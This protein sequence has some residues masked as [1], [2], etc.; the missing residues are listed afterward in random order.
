MTDVNQVRINELARELEVKAKAIIDLLPGYGVTEKKTHSS[1]IPEDVAVKVRAKI[2]G[3][4]EEESA[5]Q[6]A[7]KAESQAKETAAKARTRPAPTV[8][9]AAAP[10]A[11][12][13]APT[14]PPAA[15]APPAAT[16][17]A[18]KPAPPASATPAAPSVSATPATSAPQGVRPAAPQPGAS[19]R[20]SAPPA[21]PLRPQAP[22]AQSSAPAAQRPATPSPSGLRPQPPATRP[23]ASSATPSRAGAHAS[24]PAMPPRPP[25]PTGNRGPLPSTTHGA[26]RPLGQGAQRPAGGPRPGQPMRPQQPAQGRTFTPRPAGSPGSA[27]AR[28]FEQRRGSMPTGTRPGPRAPGRPGMLPPPFPEKLPP[29]AEPGKPLYTRKPPQ[30]Q[31]P[32]ADKREMEG[33][34]KLHPTRQRPG[35]GRMAAAVIA[36]PEPR[37]PR[38]VTI[39]EGITIRELAETPDVR[40]KTLLKTLLDRGVFASINQALDVPTATTWAETFSGVVSVV[41]L[42]EEMVL[43]VAKEETKE[44]LKPRPPVVTV[45]GHVD[46]GKTSL[47]DAIRSEDVAGGEAGGI[48]QHI[49]AYKVQVNNRS[50]VFIDTR[51]HEAF[52]RMRARGAKLADIVVLDVAADDA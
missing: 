46:H 4:S 7:A 6:T 42:E 17:P 43:E 15:S 35:A 44:S 8:P 12:A 25:L 47:L 51:G 40:A 50:V 16:V 28:P 14:R 30:R 2:K 29:K 49:G 34:R 5:A 9:V 48:T 23:A 39:T 52:T 41:S 27:P 38:E 10:S 33:E 20:P 36:P 31:R 37:P 21:T 22:A 24:R 13:P 45:M 11:S 26:S 32:V 1:S 3:A 18:A 19:L